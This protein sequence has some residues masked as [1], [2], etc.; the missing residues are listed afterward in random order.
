MY[1]RARRCRSACTS[2]SR[3]FKPRVLR[4]DADQDLCHGVRGRIGALAASAEDM[5]FARFKRS[6]KI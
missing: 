1:A 2:R 4:S 3:A 6:A 5:M